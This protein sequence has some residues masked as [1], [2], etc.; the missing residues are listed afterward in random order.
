M[1]NRRLHLF[2]HGH[3]FLFR[4]SLRALA[5]RKRNARL[6]IDFVSAPFR[7]FIGNVDRIFAGK[8]MIKDDAQTAKLFRADAEQH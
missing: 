7:G 2:H 8:A 6:Q 5:G 1:A 4:K 3:V